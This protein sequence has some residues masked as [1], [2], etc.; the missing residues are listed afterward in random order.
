MDIEIRDAKFADIEKIFGVCRPEGREHLELV[1]YKD[2]YFTQ[3][4]K[5]RSPVSGYPEVL[6]VAECESRI[7][8]YLH[9]YV[10][11][12]DGYEDNLIAL[13]IDPALSDERTK[14]VKQKLEEEF[15]LHEP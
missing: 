9:F 14:E 10:D 15:H 4:G 7:V 1:S 8:G 6:W 2:R 11:C 13:K 12:W 3:T 5:K